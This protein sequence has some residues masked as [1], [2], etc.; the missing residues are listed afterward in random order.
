MT[1]SPA[2][3]AHAAARSTPVRVV[4]LVTTLEFGG[5]EKIVLDLIRRRRAELFDERII[6][7]GA[8]GALAP[9]FVEQGVSVESV[10]RASDWFV[11]RVFRLARRLRELDTDVLHTHNPGPHLHGAFAAKLGGVPVLIHTKHGRNRVRRRSVRMLNRLA[12]R[13]SDVIVAVSDETARVSRDIERV[14]ASKVR[15]I[16][17]GIDVDHF[18]YRGPRAGRPDFRAVTVGRLDPV[19]DQATLLRAVRLALDAG[20]PIRVDIVGDGPLRAELEGLRR[21]LGLEQHVRFLGFQGDVRPFISGADVFVLPSLSEGIPLTLLEG[22]ALGLP[23]VATDVGGNSEVIVD[24][25]S[26]YL[27]QP[28]NPGVL[29]EALCRFQGDE[30]AI[31]TFGK[32]ARARVVDRFGLEGMVRQY[33]AL[34]LDC[35]ERAGRRHGLRGN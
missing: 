2:D 9:R 5:L 33:E 17:N 25:Q 30:Q 1:T 34:Y 21:E 16:L 29:A 15:T 32:A 28:G 13:F 10:A 31:E 4:H 6:C 27:V 7:V 22:M 14:P 11:G 26:G 35:L 19:K 23:A 3:R 20:K 24:G 12:A 18:A 8:P